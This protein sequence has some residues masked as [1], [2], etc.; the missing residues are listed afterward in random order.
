VA[1]DSAGGNLAAVVARRERAHLRFQ[2]LIHP[3]CDPG[4]ATPSYREFGEGFGLTAAT[5]ARC[6]DLYLDGGARHDSDAAPARASDLAGR[7][8][9]PDVAPLAAPD[10]AG[11]PPAF[12]LAASHDV[13][14]VE[15]VAYAE[16]LRAAGVPVEHRE[17]PGTTHGFWR[18]LAR[19]AVSRRAVAE[20]GAA[21]CRRRYGVLD[22]EIVVVASPADGHPRR[23][24]STG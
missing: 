24:S 4:L 2:L 5:M 23:R 20:A 11:V 3:V 14:R 10:L 22:R 17:Y 9:D 18:R 13:L 1:G 7:R 15:G 19:T 8:D 6:W 12:V 21:R 16:A